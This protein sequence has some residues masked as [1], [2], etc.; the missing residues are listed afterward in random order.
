MKKLFVVFS[1]I[2]ILL[3]LNISVNAGA[4]RAIRHATLGHI[5]EN[6]LLAQFKNADIIQSKIIEYSA[7]TGIIKT[8]LLSNNTVLFE[9]NDA[10]AFDRLNQILKSDTMVAIAQP[11]YIYTLY[12]RP[13][14][15]DPDYDTVINGKQWGLARFALNTPGK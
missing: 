6:Q 14:P 13:L 7:Q 3:N 8:Q 15:N 11:N 9:L 1:L 5:V 10:A 2:I 4:I 12:A